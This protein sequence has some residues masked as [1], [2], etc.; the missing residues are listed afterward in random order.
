MAPRC[1]V[2][3][4]LSSLL[5][6]CRHHCFL[7][8]VSTFHLPSTSLWQR[9]N[10]IPTVFHHIH[11]HQSHRTTYLCL[12]IIYSI[13]DDLSTLAAL[14]TRIDPS[15]PLATISSI[16][17]PRTPLLLGILPIF[18]SPPSLS[19]W[20]RGSRYSS[21]RSH[22]PLLLLLQ[23]P[24]MSLPTSSATAILPSDPSSRKE[25]LHASFVL[26][27]RRLVGMDAAMGDCRMN[28]GRSLRCWWFWGL[29]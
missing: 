21:Y 13:T 2:L 6:V 24:P 19:H 9:T 29:A 14:S 26:Q 17:P 22:P 20:H 16:Y 7:A 11:P 1:E 4:C 5:C 23:N 27:V 28:C 15:N 18:P 8:S 3:I 12:H 25:L 10:T